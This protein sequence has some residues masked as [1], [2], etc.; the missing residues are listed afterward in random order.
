MP[1]IA[2]EQLF[3]HVPILDMYNLLLAETTNDMSFLLPETKYDEP[4]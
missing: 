1:L 3:Q 4:F 2:R